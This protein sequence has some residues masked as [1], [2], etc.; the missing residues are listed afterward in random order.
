M[1]FQIFRQGVGMR[2]EVEPTIVQNAEKNLAAIQTVAA[3]HALATQV[4]ER[5]KLF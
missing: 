4:V 5:G 1:I 3:K 2:F